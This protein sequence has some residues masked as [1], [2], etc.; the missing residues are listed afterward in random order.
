MN[1]QGLFPLA[2]AA[3]IALG[4]VILLA[5][6]VAGLPRAARHTLAAT[7]LMAAWWMTVAIP[8]PATSI[9]KIAAATKPSVR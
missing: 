8:I 9:L 6:F 3:A 5:P 1:R 4:L 2:A 7:V